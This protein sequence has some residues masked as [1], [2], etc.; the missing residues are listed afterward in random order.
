MSA[1]PSIQPRKGLDYKDLE[2]DSRT[3]SSPSSLPDYKDLIIES[4]FI[5]IVKKGFKYKDL[6]AWCSQK[7]IATLSLRVGKKEW[8]LGVKIALK[9]VSYPSRWS[10]SFILGPLHWS[11]SWQWQPCITGCRFFQTLLWT[12][13]ADFAQFFCKMCLLYMWR[14]RIICLVWFG[15]VLPPQNSR[16][17][18]P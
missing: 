7:R 12:E 16:E 11:Y 4:I 1:A 6:D 10:F 17:S 18:W 5:I 2:I 13:L 3:S 15:S 14:S 9:L 8:D